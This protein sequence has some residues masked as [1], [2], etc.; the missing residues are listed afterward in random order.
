MQPKFTSKASKYIVGFFVFAIIISFAL[1]GFQDFFTSPNSVAKVDGTPISIREY[2]NILQAELNRFSSMLGGKSL[3]NQQINQFRIKESVLSQLIQ[4]T[5][6]VNLAN[7]MNLTPGKD[8]VRKT[9]K[10][11]PYFQT[12][13]K[14]DV[15]R[16][17]NLLQA[18]GLTPTSF[19]EMITSD[20]KFQKI[21]ETLQQVQLSDNYIKSILKLKNTTAKATAIE[22]ERESLVPFIEISKEE[23]KTF[24]SDS[25]NLEILKSFYSSIEAEYNTP[26][27]VKARHILVRIDEKNNEKEALKKIENIQKSLTS[28]NFITT[29]NKVT[30]DF[31]GKNNGGDLGWFSRG[32]MVKEFEDVAFSLKQGEISKPVKTNF[33]YHLIYVEGKKKAVTKTFDDVKEDVTKRHLQKSNRK[34]LETLSETLATDLESLLKTNNLAKLEE[35][36]KKYNLKFYKNESLDLL[37]KKIKDIDFSSLDLISS[38]KEKKSDTFANKEL[39]RFKFLRLNSFSSEKEI[40]DNILKSLNTEKESLEQKLA[41]EFQFS[42]IKELEKKASITTQPNLL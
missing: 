42:I 37:D 21:T 14:F 4:K 22:F 7:D 17:K 18:N 9:I 24:L 20:I 13:G 40:E 8:E 15:N 16:Y 11:L 30:E 35:L 6:L 12:E 41:S 26:E 19:E 10:N 39:P 2:Q 38:F 31:S 28:K 36:S 27:E 32:R 23:I 5:L 34:A 3:T 33:G 1:T 25:K 29:A